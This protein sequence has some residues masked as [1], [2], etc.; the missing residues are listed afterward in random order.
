MQKTFDKNSVLERRGENVNPADE[1][2][3]KA[4]A[5]FCRLFELIRILRAPDGCPWDRE[6]TPLSM[7][8]DLV[9]EVFEAVDAI[10]E[11][12]AAHA[13]EELGDVLL[14]SVMISYMFS[15]VKNFS[16]DEM[17]DELV[18]KLIR[19]HPHVFEQSEGKVC[20]EGI[21]KTS[22]EVLTQW[23]KIKDN[24]EGRAR[25]SILDEVPQGFPPLL[26]AFKMQKKAAKKGFDWTSLAP[27]REKILEEL[28][29]VDEAISAKENS[30]SENSRGENSNEAQ[31]HLEEEFGDLFFAVVNYARKAGVDPE[32][33][34]NAANKKFYRRFSYVEKKCAEQNISMEQKN[35]EKMD[36]FWN[37]AKSRE[38]GAD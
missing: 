11:K 35:L 27:T 10:C 6:Q 3:A 13:K 33:A 19:R 31:I 29:E 12:D 15:Q 26:R 24:V 17:F 37:E 21:A 16:V 23:D 4:A 18:E 1:E 8:R 2:S 32:L 25:D 38:N 7:R 22:D 36:A 30:L 14:N 20:A 5:A 28:S 9:E 34:M